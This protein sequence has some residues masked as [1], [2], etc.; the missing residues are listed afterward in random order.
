MALFA[1]ATLLAVGLLLV[2]E[3]R[4]SKPGVWI[5]KPLASTGF[6][7]AAVAGGAWASTYGR[8]VLAALCLSWLGD[9]LLIPKDERVFR[10]GILSFLLGHVAFLAAF[11]V[12]GVAPGWCVVALV[13]ITAPSSLVLRWLSPHLRS[14]M[15]LPV[16]AYVTVIS[17]MVV[18]AVGTVASAP[19]WTILAA[20]VAFFCSDLSVA[21][22][23]FVQKSFVNR[24]WGLPLYYGAQLLFAVSASR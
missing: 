22:D 14:E 21:R 4:G 24:V 18:A 13:G 2:S 16:R 10:A 6:V 3:R 15:K 7:A 12:R 9:V 1:L 19:S 11:L 17:L 5:C 20:A 8:V 23:R